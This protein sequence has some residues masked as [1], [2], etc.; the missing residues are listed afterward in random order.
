L[1]PREE[2]MNDVMTFPAADTQN[3]IDGCLKLGCT[4]WQIVWPHIETGTIMFRGTRCSHSEISTSPTSKT[5][6]AQQPGIYCLRYSMFVS[7]NDRGL[8]S[9]AFSWDR[10]TFSK[11]SVFQRVRNKLTSPSVT[12]A[13]RALRQ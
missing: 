7:Q 1:F 9:R 11:S 6:S 4:W 10:P 8:L 13:P 5:N 2:T 12:A 3:P